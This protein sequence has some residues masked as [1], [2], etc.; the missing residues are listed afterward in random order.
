MKDEKI[1][2]KSKNVKKEKKKYSE[3]Y[4]INYFFQNYLDKTQISMFK[5]NFKIF[6]SPESTNH[7]VE[8]QRQKKTILNSIKN[9]KM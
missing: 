7:Q 9:I 3:K 5:N 4:I 1:I 2:S 8:K 6:F